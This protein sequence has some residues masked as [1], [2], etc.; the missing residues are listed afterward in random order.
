MADYEQTNQQGPQRGASEARFNNSRIL[1]VSH[2]LH[3][4]KN[5]SPDGK[6]QVNTQ[7]KKG[8]QLIRIASISNA[9]RTG[10]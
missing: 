10:E 8:D 3:D 2:R 1:E 9:S 4:E 6:S 5:K 7:G